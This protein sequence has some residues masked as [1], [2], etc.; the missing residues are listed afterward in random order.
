M[1]V[2]VVVG[3]VVSVVDAGAV[4]ATR[5]LLHASSGT[6]VE[7]TSPEGQEELTG[8]TAEG[9]RTEADHRQPGFDGPSKQG[10]KATL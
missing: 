1:P 4:V 7:K 2:L 9:N 6:I 3:V 5:C 10:E 8:S